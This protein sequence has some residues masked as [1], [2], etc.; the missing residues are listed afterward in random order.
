MNKVSETLFPGE[1]SKTCQTQNLNDLV[2][3]SSFELEAITLAH[4]FFDLI[5]PYVSKF[6][7]SAMDGMSELFT[8]CN[9]YETRYQA[10]IKKALDEALAK[11]RA[12]NDLNSIII[13]K[14]FE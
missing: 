6:G 8:L 5:T 9:G 2:R 1:Y 4:E 14:C 3:K 7:T 11:V 12:K 10:I 13:D